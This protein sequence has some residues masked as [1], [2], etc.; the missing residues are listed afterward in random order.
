MKETSSE[1]TITPS[2]PPIWIQWPPVCL[3]GYH[4]TGPGATGISMDANNPQTGW[5]AAPCEAILQRAESSLPGPCV[6][7][8]AR[9]PFV[10]EVKSDSVS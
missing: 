6:K 10:K 5:L 7:G 4:Q 1:T 2:L 8:A 9:T 3:L